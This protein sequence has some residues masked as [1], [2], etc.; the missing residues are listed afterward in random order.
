MD[1]LIRAK[2]CR[3]LRE[4]FLNPKIRTCLIFSAITITTK[5]ERQKLNIIL[6]AFMDEITTINQKKGSNNDTRIQSYF[7]TTPE[8]TQAHC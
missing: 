4:P 2:V 3:V 7:K 6:D 8:E 1:A 5:E